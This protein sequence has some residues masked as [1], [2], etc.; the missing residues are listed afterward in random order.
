MADKKIK[1]I[2]Y[3]L[4]NYERVVQTNCYYVDK[5]MY[6]NTIEEASDYLFFIRP[7]RFGKSLLLSMME[8]YYDVHYKDR[9][10]ELFKGTWVFD[11]PTSERGSYLVLSFNFSAVDPSPGEVEASFLNQVQDTALKFISKYC[12]YLSANPNRDYFVEKIK[13]SRSASDILSTLLH[14][15]KHAQQ[16]LYVLIDDYDTFTNSILSTD[17]DYAYRELTHGTGFFLSFFSALKLGTSGAGAPI[18]RSF[19]TGVSPITMDDVTYVYNIGE[20]TSMDPAFKTMLGF[21]EEDVIEMIEYYRSKG[22]IQH[23]TAYLMEI[24]SQ[25]YGNYLSSEDD[26]VKLFNSDT[27]IYIIDYYLSRNKFD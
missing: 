24:M 22:R 12:D 9:F 17:G 8:M 23:P 19:I 21:T 1:R 18:S 2:P 6:L 20:N 25:W 3:G 11:H 13:E 15:C 5:T 10:E 14:L 7:R 4:A 26:D 16:K 27:I